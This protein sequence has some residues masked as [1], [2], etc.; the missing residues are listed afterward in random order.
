MEALA[1]GGVGRL[2][3]VDHD[4]VQESSINRQA[5]AFKSTVGRKKVE[6]MRGMIADINLTADVLALERFVLAE[7]LPELFADVEAAAGPL[8]YVVDAIDT[9]SA[10]LA[11]AKFA[12]ERGLRLISSMGAVNKLHLEVPRFAD[13]SHTVNC[14]LCRVMRK[15]ARKRGIRHL[16]VLYSCEQPAKV[17]PREGAERRER[18]NLGT[19]SYLPPIMGQMIAAEAIRELAGSAHD[20][21]AGASGVTARARSAARAW[22]FAKRMRRRGPRTRGWKMQK[23]G[24]DERGRV[25]AD[26]CVGCAK[27]GG[28]CAG[29]AAGAVRPALPSGFSARCFRCCRRGARRRSG[30]AVGHGDARGI[31]ACLRRAGGVRQRAGGVGAAPVAGGGRSLRCGGYRPV[32]AAGPGCSV[33]RG[34]GA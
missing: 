2:V 13:L 20:G 30:H 23:D 17:P 31:R 9:V 8:D 12:E 34:S 28:R 21:R 19:A 29:G 32:R 27:H 6:V 1:R 22:R 7:T 18:S 14:P 25:W 5:I 4:V 33:H 16:R 3:V 11:L 10:K 15:E 26:A 24:G